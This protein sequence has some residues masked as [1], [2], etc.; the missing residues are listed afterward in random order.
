M[1]RTKKFK[2]TMDLKKDLKFRF[3][4]DSEGIPE[5]LRTI[6]YYQVSLGG[7]VTR[8]DFAEKSEATKFY[9]RLENIIPDEVFLQAKAIVN[10][11]KVL[12]TSGFDPD[13]PDLQDV[14]HQA[15]K[16]KVLKMSSGDPVLYAAFMKQVSDKHNQLVSEFTKDLYSRK[17]Q[18][19]QALIL[20]L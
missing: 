2:G 11:G 3:L 7:P 5:Y 17:L 1:S 15:V 13:D 18:E 10:Q 6:V 8:R 20:T 9:K 14:Y 12:G 16:D 19:N 4:F